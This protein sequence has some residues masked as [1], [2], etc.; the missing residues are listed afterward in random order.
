MPEDDESDEKFVTAAVL[1]ALK[2]DADEA[3]RARLE[4]VY[5]AAF[6]RDFAQRVLTLNDEEA[7]LIVVSLAREG[8]ADFRLTLAFPTILRGLYAGPD[9]YAEGRKLYDAGH[10]RTGVSTA[11]GSRSG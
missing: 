1:S 2:A 6:V 10:A 3:E 4:G 11:R 8:S 7:A 9:T 5:R